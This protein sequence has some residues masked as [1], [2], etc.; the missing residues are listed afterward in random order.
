MT[1]QQ[2]QG[3]AKLPRSVNYGTQL[4]EDLILTRAKVPSATLGFQIG[5]K[6]AK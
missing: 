6:I 1:L 4:I 5:N 2:T 3:L